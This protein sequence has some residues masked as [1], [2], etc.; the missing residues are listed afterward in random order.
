MQVGDPN[1]SGPCA[2]LVRAG[3]VFVNR[4]GRSGVELGGG[5]VVARSPTPAKATP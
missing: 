3:S 4:S 2:G 1:F 5:V